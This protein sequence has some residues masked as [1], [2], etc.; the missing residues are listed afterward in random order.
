MAALPPH[1]GAMVRR[2]GGFRGLSVMRHAVFAAAVAACV[3]LA[4]APAR[5]TDP[6]F[7]TNSR[8]GLAPPSGFVPSA[9]F[10][11]FENPQP[12]AGIVRLDRPAEAF[13]E[14]EKTSTEEAL[15]TRG[16]TVETREP[17]ELRGAR[18]FLLTGQHV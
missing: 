7:P 5:A 18:G 16:R 15:R 2:A 17:I 10:P 3:A 4:G 13:P 9:Q 1:V 12:N 8:I 14:I 11:G 6:V